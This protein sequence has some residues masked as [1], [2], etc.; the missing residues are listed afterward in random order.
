LVP[1]ITQSKLNS[2]C[3]DAVNWIR[4]AL[5]LDLMHYIVVFVNFCVGESSVPR[6]I[7]KQ[8]RVS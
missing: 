1:V 8:K 2:S 7:C 5:L 4:L 3:D 6:C